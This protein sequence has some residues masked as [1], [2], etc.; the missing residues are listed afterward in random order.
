MPR[1]TPSL[2]PFQFRHEVACL[3]FVSKKL[4]NIPV[5]KIYA[6]DDGSS[7]SGQIFAAEEFREGQR[8]STAWPQ[9]E[10]NENSQICLEI[11]NV[12][13]TLG[14]HDSIPSMDQQYNHLQVL[15]SRQR[16]CLTAEYVQSSRPLLEGANH[17]HRPSSIRHGATTLGH[18]KIARN[19]L[20]LA[21]ITR[22]S[23]ILMPM[24]TT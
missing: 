22:Y 13:A 9:L 17:S 23:T 12:V 21:T 20:F 11:A 7:I 2:Q 6:W 16:N 4:P 14:K 19:T 15:P 18:I 5:P 8:L 1:D 10:E 24:M 3:Q